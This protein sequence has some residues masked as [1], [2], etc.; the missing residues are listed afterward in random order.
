MKTSLAISLP[1]GTYAQ[2]AVQSRLAT[3]QF[4]GTGAR[5]IDPNYQ[6]EIK[7]VLFNHFAKDVIVKAGDCIA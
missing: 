1:P 6:G 5:V 3:R 4:I 2:I 7:V